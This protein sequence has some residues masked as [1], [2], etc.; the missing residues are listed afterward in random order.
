MELHG[1]AF[2]HHLADVQSHQNPSRYESGTK[3]DA[4][5]VTIDYFRE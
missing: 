3:K 2:L 4:K 1:V 5:M